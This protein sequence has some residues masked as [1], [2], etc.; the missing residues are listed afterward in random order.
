MK[1]FL[2]FCL[3]V[4]FGWICLN[5]YRK[6][7]PKEWAR[8][9]NKL[10]GSRRVRWVVPGNL[11]YRENELVENA[12]TLAYHNLNDAIKHSNLSAT[13]KSEL[14]VKAQKIPDTIVD[15]MEKI[16]RLRKLKS[17]L[18]SGY[19]SEEITEV[20]SMEKGIISEIE[21]SMKILSSIPVKL[22]KMELAQ[23]DRS[24]ERLL[25]ELDESNQRMQDVS[26][27]WTDLRSSDF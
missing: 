15:S 23:G 22:T 17:S 16:S 3:I 18:D 11:S 25:A 13:E 8:L 7:R 2:F 24:F 27:S 26:D 1:T 10:T 6:Y 20:E 14:K 12:H 5:M 4:F 21:S 19:S 9:Q